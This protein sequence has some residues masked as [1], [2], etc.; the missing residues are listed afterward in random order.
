MSVNDQAPSCVI[1][2]LCKLRGYNDVED[3]VEEMRVEAKKQ[4]SVKTFTLKQ[5][6]TTPDLKLPII[7][8]VIRQVAK[9]WSGLCPVGEMLQYISNIIIWL[10]I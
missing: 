1:A 6:L 2:A 7:I 8:A 5:L 3:E 10:L 9:L 4:S